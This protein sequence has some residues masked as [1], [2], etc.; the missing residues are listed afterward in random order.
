VATPSDMN[1]PPAVRRAGWVR[2][3]SG[4]GAEAGVRYGP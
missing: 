4:S 2:V 3:R 1:N